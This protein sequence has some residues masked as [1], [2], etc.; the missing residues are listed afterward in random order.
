MV[1]AL[2]AA[3][4]AAGDGDDRASAAYLPACGEGFAKK[5][6]KR[7]RFRFAGTTTNETRWGDGAETYLYRG[8]VKRMRCYGTRVDYWQTKGTFTRTF[9]NIYARDVPGCGEDPPYGALADGPTTTTP[10]R[11]FGADIGFSWS[12][13]QYSTG[14]FNPANPR[15]VTGTYR[16]LNNGYT[17]PYTFIHRS[18]SEY[19]RKGV[20]KRVVKGKA[21]HRDIERYKYKVHWKLTAIR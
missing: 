10:L 9:K 18:T 5:P 4:P 6:P 17:A 7:Y 20:P 15:F 19:T 2:A 3:G 1:C 11:R 13:N 16:C 8:V 21:N 14:A 12:G